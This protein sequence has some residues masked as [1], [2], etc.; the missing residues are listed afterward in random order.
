MCNEID[1]Q[2]WGERC[3]YVWWEELGEYKLTGG[4]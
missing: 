2:K 4:F 3:M 1:V